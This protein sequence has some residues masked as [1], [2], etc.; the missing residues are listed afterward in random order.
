MSCE[1]TDQQ[2]I[3]FR[4]G[5]VEAMTVF[6][7]PGTINEASESVQKEVENRISKTSIVFEA[8]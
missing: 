3:H 6:K 2:P 8:L 1:D 7:E 5:T 4:R